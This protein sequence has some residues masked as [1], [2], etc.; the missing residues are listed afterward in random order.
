MKIKALIK[1][2]DKFDHMQFRLLLEE[3]VKKGGKEA[4]NLIAQY[5]TSEDVESLI[6]INIIRIMGYIRSTTFL[7]PLRRTLESQENLNLRKAAI[8]SIAKFNDKRALN[9]LN[10][11]IQRIN[12]PILRESISTEISRIKKD[13][14]ILGLMPKFLN[15]VD[16]PKTFRTTLEVL[17]QVL[18]PDDAHQFIYHL[19][20]ETPFVD[21]GAFE[22]LCHRGSDSVK[23][24]IFDY[25]RAKLKEVTCYE[26]DECLSLVYL[27]AQLDHFITRNPETINFVLKEL[28]DIYKRVKDPE[29]KNLIIHIFSTSPK[30]E[31]LAF[32]EEI[33]NKDESRREMVIEKLKWNEDGAYILLY[34]YKNQEELKEQLVL[35]LVTTL[36]GSEYLTETFDSI[37]PGY[38]KL[39]LD[40]I[41]PENY[42]FFLPL[43]ERFLLAD[44]F[45]HKKFA[46][47]KMSQNRDFNFHPILFNPKHEKDFL[48]MHHEY[49]SVINLLY[50]VKTFVYFIT[51]IIHQDNARPL[52]RKYYNFENSFLKAEAIITLPSQEVL[53]KF[54]DRLTKFNNKD[55]NLDVLTSLYYIKTFDQNTL[56]YMQNAMDEFKALRGTRLSPEEKGILNKINSNFL[57]INSDL[58]KI[59]AAQSNIARFLE[60]EFPDFELLDYILNKHVMAFFANRQTLINRIRKTFKL[61][62]E[63]DAYDSVKYLLKHPK[64]SIY[65]N[66]EI[67]KACKSTNYLLK[68][69]AEKLKEKMPGAMRIV[70]VFSEDYL[71]SYFKDQLHE[72]VPEAFVEENAEISPKDILITDYTSMDELRS[73]NRVKTKQ[74]Y[75][76][77]DD[78]AQFADIKDFKPKVFAP[79]FNLYKFMRVLIPELFAEIEETNQEK[80]DE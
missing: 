48:R 16:D 3:L 58:K 57:T 64:L 68:Q 6:R 13:N 18:S 20:S 47:E 71:Y 28:K 73:E 11:A 39:I 2:A 50:P 22:I 23:F 14:P 21:D 27:I 1:K 29:V 34:K 17:K 10:A 51:T 12:N 41:I 72:L 79:P 38:Q 8:I 5:A 25:F 74:L 56:I 49:I 9:M 70:L 63:L 76:L 52:M 40:N 60:K 35:G 65:F 67:E 75:V 61:P 59:Q 4:E 77:L 44:N 33:Y 37:S 78:P 45:G 53:S 7:V 66:E 62:K 43:I 15:A 32:L 69:D 54:I 19:K 46:L 24:S 36:K 55:F 26:E 42:S 31:V 80:Q 30:R